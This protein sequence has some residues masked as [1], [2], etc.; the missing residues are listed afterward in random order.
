MSLSE[1]VEASG[2][3]AGLPRDFISQL[4][5]SSSTKIGPRILAISLI[6][7]FLAREERLLVL[8]LTPAPEEAIRLSCD[9]S[10]TRRANAAGR[11][12]FFFF[13]KAVS[14]L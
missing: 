7:F 1:S 11:A 5:S 10:L 12:R 6:G 14:T 8:V 13:F 2:L 3:L 4:S 9:D